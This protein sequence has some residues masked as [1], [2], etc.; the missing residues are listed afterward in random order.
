MISACLVVAVSLPS[1]KYVYGRLVEGDRRA[2]AASMSQTLFG[3]ASPATDPPRARATF[4][5]RFLI[6]PNR[7][8][9]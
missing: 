4:Y 2:V 6:G 9:L 7:Q 1:S 8:L 5:G 3:S